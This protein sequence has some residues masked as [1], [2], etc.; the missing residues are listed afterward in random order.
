MTLLLAESMLRSGVLGAGAWLLLRL[1]RVRDPARELAVWRAVLLASACMPLLLPALRAAM[2]AVTSG[3]ALPPALVPTHATV[4][5]G[6]TEGVVIGYV[7]VTLVL[8]SRV[9]L[10]L[11][12][13]TR[14][15]RGAARIPA[16]SADGIAVRCSVEVAGPSAIARGVLL[17]HGWEH[18][19]TEVLERVL[20]HER[21]HVR[22]GDFAWMLLARVYRG[23]C[24]ANPLAWWMERRLALLAEQRSDDAV[25][26]SHPDAIGYAEMLLTFSR[27]SAPR[28]SLGIS[29]RGTL[30]CRIDRILA[31][32]D[33]TPSHLRRTSTLLTVCAIALASVAAPWLALKPASLVAQKS[34][35][36][37]I[38]AE[39]APL[40]P[41]ESTLAPLAPLATRSAPAADKP[42]G[43]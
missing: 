10:G 36:A 8:L 23:A 37:P 25:L 5:R 43:L 26:A 29:R 17:P 34:R 22:H 18:W 35:L 11:F 42:G 15:W 6:A 40:R 9:G 20:A 32:N 39:L 21:A 13:V 7:A 14:V 41:L 38:D 19:S 30:A 1:L 33:T 31:G 12:A 4:A 24:W 27:V 28:L 2:P 16:L 3:I